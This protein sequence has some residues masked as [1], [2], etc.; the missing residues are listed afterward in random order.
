MSVYTSYFRAPNPLGRLKKMRAVSV[1]EEQ[2]SSQEGLP[3]RGAADLEEAGAK[4]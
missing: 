1:I 4:S 3:G 2:T